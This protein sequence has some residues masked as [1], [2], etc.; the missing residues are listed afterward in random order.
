VW[1]RCPAALPRRIGMAYA[2]VVSVRDFEGDRMAA[3]SVGPPMPLRALPDSFWI[4]RISIFSLLSG[5]LILNGAPQA[6]SSSL[7]MPAFEVGLRQRTGFFVAAFLF[8]TLPTQ[9]ST[10]R[11]MQC[12][13][14]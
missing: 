14:S 13:G 1:L 12:T 11:E 8:W 6:Q 3:N 10:W 9:L 7:D 4:C 2:H 5:W